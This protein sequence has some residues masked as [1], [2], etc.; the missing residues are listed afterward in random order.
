[1]ANNNSDI[2]TYTFASTDGLLLD[3]NLWMLL[4]G[5]NPPGDR[6]V[7]TYSEAFRRIL[8]AKS[9]IHLDVLVLSE[10]VNRFARL[11]HGFM[12]DQNLALPRDFKKFRGTPHFVAIAERIRD[13]AKQLAKYCSRIESGFANLPLE[14]VLDYFSRGT[15]DFNDQ[16]LTELCK[17]R[18]LKLVTDDC[19]FQFPGLAV[20]T[21]NSRLLH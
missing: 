19:D 18:G 6:R 20:I 10:F 8:I 15:S 9:Q 3:A 14:E 12:C 5:P 4:Y 13:A 16:V 2:R 21:A 17:R 1:M 11:E 7:R